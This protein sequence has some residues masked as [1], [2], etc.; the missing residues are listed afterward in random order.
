MQAST[1]DYYAVLQVL[2]TATQQEI[3]DAYKRAALKWHPDRVPTDSPER[4]NRTAKF[5]LIND[6]YYTLSEPSR[7][8]AYDLARPFTSSAPG[9]DPDTSFPS[10][11]PSN[12]GPSSKPDGGGF[13]FPG[14]S[15]FGFG[16]GSKTPDRESTSNAQFGSVFE[17]MMREEG[18]AEGDQAVPTRKF[19]SLIGAASGAA[20]G[21]I[22]ANAPGAI[23]GGV[24]GNRLGAVRD[25]RGK[26][27]FEVYRE[28]PQADKAKL[29]A[30]MA[31]KVFGY[32]VSA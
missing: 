6:A 17:E 1:P 23:A 4:A 14:S 15:F 2:P 26:S 7:R 27:V 24:A 5:Q 18:L 8:R 3:R 10:S 20:M 16:S 13:S 22:V 29:L 9:P 28:L 19:W 11:G 31:A 21:F 12:S 32:A 30:E 25:K